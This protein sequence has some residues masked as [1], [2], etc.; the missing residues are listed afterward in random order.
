M[1][2]VPSG[3]YGRC[4]RLDQFIA[5]H[6]ALWEHS[7]MQQFL[8]DEHRR[9]QLIQAVCA[10]T[11]ENREA[12]DKVFASFYTEVRFTS[13]ILKT[14][15]WKAVR[16]DQ[17]R[18]RRT[19]QQPLIMDKPLNPDQPE[20]IIDSF[21]STNTPEPERWLP[22]KAQDLR[23]CIGD[24]FLYKALSQLTD[25]QYAVLHKKFLEEK[26]NKAI[27]GEW[28]I[29]PQAV[30]KTKQAALSKLRSFMEG[31]RNT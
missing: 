24:A 6:P 26:T 30:Y 4:R 22:E 31:G 16:Y 20:T 10:P 14:L 7:V 8:Q 28:N 11:P 13:Y 5:D 27:A 12:L 19:R 23:Q 29:S 18:Q 15:H 17:K 9:E 3:L 21:V 25:H 1:E 2:H